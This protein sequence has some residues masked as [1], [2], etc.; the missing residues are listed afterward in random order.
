MG[1][2]EPSVEPMSFINHTECH[3]IDR[4]LLSP[5][6][7]PPN[8]TM[9]TN[10]S[11]PT[12]ETYPQPGINNPIN[13]NCQCV[14]YFKVFYQRIEND[15][16]DGVVRSDQQLCRCDC[17]SENVNCDLLKTGIDGFSIADRR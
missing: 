4:R 10:N 15:E 12:A 11:R 9:T 6:R 14:K 16:D 2:R 8:T 7:H 5:N 1:K 17:E 13:N 3:C